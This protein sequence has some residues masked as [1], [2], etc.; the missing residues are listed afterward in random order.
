MSETHHRLRG[1]KDGELLPLIE[2]L[3]AAGF[4]ITAID[5]SPVSYIAARNLLILDRPK[6][7]LCRYLRNHNKKYDGE[8]S[9]L[10]IVSDEEIP[11]TV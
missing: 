1:G 9:W 8:T 6:C 3:K 7:M 4:T 5:S 10:L 11:D 2:N